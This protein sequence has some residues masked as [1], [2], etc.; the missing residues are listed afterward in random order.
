M[1]SSITSFACLGEATREESLAL[2]QAQRVIEHLQA[3][4]FAS[5]FACFNATGEDDPPGVPAPGPGFAVAGLR[6]RPGDPDGMPGEIL[7]P[8]A[9]EL[10]AELR[11]TLVDS[12]F[13][14]PRDLNADGIDSLDHALDYEVL[15]I[16]VRVEWSGVIDHSIELQTILRNSNR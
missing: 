4:D 8:V 1:A 9:P 16:R 11:E 13:G 6:T 15:P 12:S 2:L 10:P 3:Q 7:F 14:F 5:V